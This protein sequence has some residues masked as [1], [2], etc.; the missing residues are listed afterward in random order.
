MTFIDTSSHLEFTAADEVDAPR[1]TAPT[2]PS[3]SGLEWSVI[4]L[5]QR[6]RVSSLREPG[7]IATALRTVFGT[8][9][10]GR[11][12][13]ERLE[14]LRRIA[15]FA[16]HHGYSVPMSELRTFLKAGFSTDHYEMLQA[17]IARTRTA[18][19]SRG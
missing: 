13:D 10:P 14:A 15:V 17:S 11:L 5:A 6:D 2:A 1:D 18:R 7:R 16:W 12:A 9:R 4:A 19:N 3:F 8:G